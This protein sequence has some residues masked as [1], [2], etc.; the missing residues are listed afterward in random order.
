M[1]ALLLFPQ[2]AAAAAGLHLAD[3]IAAA[4]PSLNASSAG[5]LTAWTE[6]ELYEFCDEAAKRLASR[7]GGFVERDATIALVVGTHTYT[8][9]ARHLSTIHLSLGTAALRPASAAELEALSATWV[10]DTGA[11]A[12]SYWIQDGVGLEQFRVYPIPAAGL[13]G[14]FGVIFHRYPAAIAAGSA[15]IAAARCL[16]DYF[17]LRILEAARGKESR[18]AMP[19]AAAWCGQAAEV[20]EQACRAYWGEVQ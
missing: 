6:T 5:E 2:G 19:E 9:P 17:T 18:E 15:T 8:L 3:A 7:M 13:S 10:E 12:L 20:Y 11:A 14:N 1:L 16:L 4:I